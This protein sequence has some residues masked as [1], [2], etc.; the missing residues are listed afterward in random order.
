MSID[1]KNTGNIRPNH[2]LAEYDKGK[3]TGE[4]ID[5]CTI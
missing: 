1:N 3:E 5:E 4:N 2:W